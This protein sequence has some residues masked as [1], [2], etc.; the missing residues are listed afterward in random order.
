MAKLSF[1]SKKGKRELFVDIR[2][3]APG[4]DKQT[5]FCALKTEKFAHGPWHLALPLN[6][7]KAIK[8]DSWSHTCGASFNWAIKK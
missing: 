8:L 1:L 6:Y 7:N 3:D 5:S 4:K 2:D